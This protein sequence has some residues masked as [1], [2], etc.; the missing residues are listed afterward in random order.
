MLPVTSFHILK[1]A[2][3]KWNED[4]GSRLGAAFAYYALFS[5][6]PLLVIAVHI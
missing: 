2:I 5:I 3:Q 1:R 4:G 6:A